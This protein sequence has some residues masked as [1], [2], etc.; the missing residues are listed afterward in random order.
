MQLHAFII[1]LVCAIAASGLFPDDFG[2]HNR[3]KRA[4]SVPRGIEESPLLPRHVTPVGYHV[5]LQP[6]PQKGYFQGRVEVNI[7]CLTPTNTVILNAGDNLSISKADISVIDPADSFGEYRPIKRVSVVEVRRGSPK[8]WCEVKLSD[9]L[10]QGQLYQLTLEFASDLRNGSCQEAMYFDSYSD[11]CSDEEA[12]VN[13]TDKRGDFTERWFVATDMTRNKARKVFPC[14]DEL[15]YKA[16]FDISIGRPERMR[17]LSN[18]ALR[19]SEKMLYQSGWVWDNF[20]TTPPM[21]TFSVNIFIFDPDVIVPL[22]PRRD[23]GST[24]LHM[25][26]PVDLRDDMQNIGDKILQT[27]KT[28]ETYLQMKYPLPDLQI[29]V[30]PGIWSSH[31]GFGLSVFSDDVKSYSWPLS[32]LKYMGDQWL[33]HLTTPHSWSE[34]SFGNSL[35]YYVSYIGYTAALADTRAIQSLNWGI[36]YSVLTRSSTPHISSIGTTVLRMLNYTLG[37]NIVRSAFDSFLHDRLYETFASDDMVLAIEDQAQ[38]HADL[39]PGVTVSKIVSS[40]MKVQQFPVVTVRRNYHTRTAYVEQH[41]FTRNKSDGSSER[42]GDLWYVPLVLLRS[43]QREGRLL[44]QV[45]W[46]K[47]EE[48]ITLENMPPS[49]S[50]ILV[51]PDIIGLFVVN[52][53]PANWRLILQHLKTK[54]SSIRLSA[55]TRAKLLTDAGLLADAGDLSYDV[56]FDL[57]LMLSDENDV[58][59]FYAFNGFFQNLR[60]KLQY[61][62]IR[63]LLKEYIWKLFS[64]LYEQYGGFNEELMHNEMTPQGIVMTIMCHY[65]AED[66]TEALAAKY[67]PG[68]YTQED[69]IVLQWGEHYIWEETLVKILGH[70]E[71]NETDLDALKYFASCTQQ[72]ERIDKL[73]DA[74]VLNNSLCDEDILDVI[75]KIG[76]PYLLFNFMSYNWSEIKEKYEHK[77]DI[78]EKLVSEIT[79]KFVTSDGYDLVSDFYAARQR[80]TPS[81]LPVLRNTMQAI[82][83]HTKW[84]D[85]SVSQIESWIHQYLSEY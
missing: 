65:G 67:K 42:R 34:A 81:L 29:V 36:I 78:M 54:G 62:R 77:P 20:E 14:F 13:T 80:D 17:S 44:D 59:P 72:E 18:M 46:M 37:E 66:C 56:P 9:V 15:S 21:S 84:T 83:E 7:S 57:S 19:K 26:A 52:Y 40:W 23:L 10:Q 76:D 3:R 85:R 8:E 30:A 39:P 70:N 61:T 22:E 27:V 41:A 35:S 33:V 32:L 58:E 75:N 73:L 2:N 45:L 55:T 12:D 68:T 69:C 49:D 28:I 48:K 51:D 53:D 50:F 16:P 64:P 5:W 4:L 71:N 79:S 1:A 25:Y 11:E 43:D 60:N 82:K 63:T 47:K 6:I 24:T 31:E 74:V 38:R